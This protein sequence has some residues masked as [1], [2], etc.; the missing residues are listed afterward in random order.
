M[1]NIIPKEKEFISLPNILAYDTACQLR[2]YTTNQ[3]KRLE[4]EGK[5]SK[6]LKILDNLKMVIDKLHFS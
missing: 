3:I 2:Q 6:R 5:I 1:I 4:I